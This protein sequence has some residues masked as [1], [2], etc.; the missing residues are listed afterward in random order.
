[1]RPNQ[2]LQTAA[3]HLSQAIDFTQVN[4]RD[5]T[6]RA[7]ALWR[8]NPHEHEENAIAL[9]LALKAQPSQPARAAGQDLLAQI[10]Q[11]CGNVAIYNLAISKLTGDDTQIDMKGANILLER[12]I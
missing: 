8:E 2:G 9:V 5:Y 6:R 3:E 1:M 4:P 7:L 10:A 12:V 11:G